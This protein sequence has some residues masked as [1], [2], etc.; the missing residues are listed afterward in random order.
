[1]SAGGSHP[2]GS[3]ERLHR[4]FEAIWSNP[5][6]LRRLTVVNHSVIGKRFLVT[7]FFFFLVG[8][9]LAMLIR[10]Q[11]ATAD[12][13][14]VG[15]DAYN[16]IF[17]MHGTVMMFLFAIPMIE[18]LVLYFL[19]KFFGARD[20]AFPRLSAF[21]Y[22]CY[23]FGGAIILGSTIFGVAPDSGWFMYTPL[24]S[25]EF[26]PGVN[27][28]VWLLGVT[29]V[30][31]SA[32]AIGIELVVTILKIRGAGMA[33][34]RMPLFGWYIFVTA[35]MIVLGFPP[36][37]LASIMLE[38]ERA[39]DWPF[40]IADR[41]GDS[42]LWQHLFWLF[43]HPEVYIIFLPGAAIVSTLIPTFAR[44]PFVGY[45]AVVV[46]LLAMGFLSF[47]LWVHH[48]YVTGIPYLALS[49]FF[50]FFMLVAIPTSVQFFAWLATLWAGRPVLRLPMLYLFGFLVIFVFGG[51]TGVM[52][53][54]VPFDWQA[55]D[56]HFVVAHLHYVLV[57]G[58]VF[59][60][61]AGAYYWMPQ[62]TGR[63]P[64]ERLGQWAFWLIF[65]G[66]NLTFFIM[67]FTGLMGMPRRVYTYHPDFGWDLFNLISSVGAFIMATGFAALIIDLVVHARHGAKAPHNPWEAG[68]LEWAMPTPP[69]IY[70][71]ASLPHVE[72][73]EPLWDRPEL[74]AEMAEGCHYLAIPRNGW[75][76]T[77][78]VDAMTGRPEQIVILPGPSWLPFLSAAAMAVFFLGFLFQVYPVAIAGAGVAAILF[79]IWGW[80][81][82]LKE[83]HEPLPAGGDLELPVHATVDG[84]PGWWGSCI[85]FV[86]DGTFLASLLFGYLF[87]W[88]VAPGWPPPSFIEPSTVIPAVAILGS[89]TGFMASHLAVRRNAA[90]ALGAAMMWL[91]IALLAGIGAAAAFLAVPL[92]AIE[93]P[94]TH[95]Y[96][97]TTALIA[98]YAAF[99]CGV[100]TLMSAHAGLRAFS[101]YISPQRS[102]DLRV[103]RLWW[104]YALGRAL[105]ILAVLFAFPALVTS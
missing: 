105:L 7:G 2:E 35:F 80:Q 45:T 47:A 85:T 83:D 38:V 30:E 6:G 63:M 22:F 100:V 13:D 51:L 94:T 88:S 81:N 33:L 28:D 52:V 75:Q 16:Q 12:N 72:T 18:G 24:S 14:F 99:H 11:L 60:L 64:S 27:A 55:H 104:G 36:L 91:T 97:A 73:R 9:I 8:G 48:M 71:F 92:T 3:V 49:F 40:F 62:M 56:T 57:G 43:G 61:L 53:A 70:N 59:P 5:G 79:L 34:Q 78:G 96:H 21:G 31:I 32:V 86:A 41:G 37:I 58:F 103:L 26:T 19:P 42:L 10:A 1:M 77:L 84:A 66:F 20:L 98:I 29:F 102:L 44:R 69:P 68:T 67:H 23:L 65:I 46:A 17:T 101:G 39:F 4:E 15:H 25:R 74:P 54:L 50:F 90:G 93:S 76:E 82:G 89:A 87:L 95:A